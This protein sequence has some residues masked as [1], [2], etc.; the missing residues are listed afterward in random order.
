MAGLSEMVGD[1]AL[2]PGCG[3]RLAKSADHG[4]RYQCPQCEGRLM[5]LSPFEQLLKDGLGAKLWV[6]SSDGPGGRPCPFC[7][8]AM[9]QAAGTDTPDGLQL[10]HTCQQVWIPA[11]ASD[12]LASHAAAG[13]TLPAPVAQLPERCDNCGAPLQVDPAGRCV[14][15]HT[16]LMAPEPVT[17]NFESAPESTGSRLLDAVAAFMGR[18]GAGD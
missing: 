2:C 11:G 4:M 6:A 13:A 12:W 17:I 5:G 9:R 16:Q 10:C 1:D 3:A 7:H 18:P 14:Y 8:Q 15:C